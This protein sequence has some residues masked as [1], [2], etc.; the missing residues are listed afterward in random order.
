M[1]KVTLTIASKDYIVSMDDAFAQYFQKDIDKFKNENGALSIQD[2]L[3]AYTHKC[4]EN[5]KQSKQ[6]EILKK[7]IEEK[8]RGQ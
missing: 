5:F 2:L 1:K 7:D 6:M 3:R 4:N 8:M